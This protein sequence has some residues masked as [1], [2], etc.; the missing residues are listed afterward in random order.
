MRVEV[1]D[2]RPSDSD[3]LIPSIEAHQRLTGR[4]PDLVSADAGFYTAKNDSRAQEMG[5]KRSQ[6]RT[7]TLRA[8]S[9]N[10]TRNSAGSRKGRSGGPDRRAESVC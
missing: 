9:A 4:T 3:L 10:S 8:P 5:V 6:F 2:R 7:E 1:Y